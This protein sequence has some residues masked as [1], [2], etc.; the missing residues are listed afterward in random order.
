MIN[1]SCCSQDDYDKYIGKLVR[2]VQITEYSTYYEE[3]N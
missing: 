1:I 2:L 3:I